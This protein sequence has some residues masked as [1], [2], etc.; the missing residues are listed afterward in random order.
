MEK[1][2]LAVTRYNPSL[3]E[4]FRVETPIGDAVNSL[5][6]LKLWI[7]GANPLSARTHF[8]RLAVAGEYA[9]YA[10]FPKTGRTNQ[11]RVHLAAVGAWIVGDKM[12]HADETVFLEFH[13]KGLT[14]RVLRETLFPRHMLHNAAIRGPA[15]LPS[16]LAESPVICP[17]PSD[18]MAF[19]PMDE[20]LRAGNVSANPETQVAFLHGLIEEYG[21]RD[22]DDEPVVGNADGTP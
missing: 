6:R 8:V 11:I 7:G 14:E 20:L 18:M 13:E 16:L 10:C 3:P 9:L 2:Y 17:L 19:K 4:R 22:F 15:S 1:M 12:Y 21:S 5:I